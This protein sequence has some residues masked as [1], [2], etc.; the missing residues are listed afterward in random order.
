[1]SS[2]RTVSSNNGSVDKRILLIGG[3]I[4]ILAI[5]FWAGSRVPQ[6]DEKAAMGGETSFNSLGFET[7]LQV[8][9]EHS[10]TRKILYTTVNWAETNKKGM[11]FG[12]LFASCLMTLFTVLS[13][14]SF[15]SG[16]ANSALGVLIGA[17]L[18]VCVNCA[19][20][21]AQGMSARGAR[22]ETTLATM[23][24]SPTMNFI[25]LTMLFSMFPI[26]LVVIK[27]AFT[28]GFIL[29]VIPV[30]ARFVLNREVTM[31]LRGEL[32][33]AL[34]PS[35]PIPGP[36]DDSTRQAMA[37]WPRT[38]SWV[39]KELFRNLGYILRTTV[40]LMLLAGFLGSAM[41]TVIPWG[42][43]A[44]VVPSG[45]RLTT[46]VGMGVVALVGT[47]LPVPIAFDVIICSVLLA[48]GMP[49]K[50]VTILLFTLGIYSV[51]S[52]SIVWQAISTRA[53]VVLFVLLAA[54]GVVAGGLG[55]IF[56]KKSLLRNQQILVE[57]F[58]NNKELEEP[59]FRLERAPSSSRED[60]PLAE[61]LGAQSGIPSRLPV[62]AEEGIV[63]HRFPFQ[64]SKAGD[65]PFSRFGGGVFGLNE[66][67][68]FSFF[69]VNLPF[70]QGHGRTISTGDVHNDSWVDVLFTSEAGLSLYANQQG[71]SFVP[72]VVDIPALDDA[73]VVNAALVDLNN[74]GWLDIFLST[75]TKGNHLIYND[76]EGG[77]SAA[78]YHAVPTADN[79][80]MTTAFAFGDLD[81]DGDLDVVIGKW[82]FALT[83]TTWNT[84][85]RS[86]NAVLFNEGGSF[87]YQ[88]L[89][90]IPGAP[91]TILITD[92]N[93]DGHQ[94]VIVGNDFAAPDIFYLGDG[95]GSFEILTKADGLVPH[96]TTSTMSIAVGD[97][98][99]DLQQEIFFGDI[100][101]YPDDDKEHPHMSY[102][103]VCELVADAAERQTCLV[104]AEMHDLF[105][106]MVLTRDVSACLGIAQEQYQQE[107][108][109]LF[110][111]Q[112]PRMER[113]R[114][115]CA[116]LPESW[117]TMNLMCATHS[118]SPF[119][120][121]EQ[122]LAP[123]IPQTRD[124]NVLLMRGEDGL[125]RDRAAEMGV[126]LAGW[127]WTIKFA[128]LDNDE[129]MDLYGVNGTFLAREVRESNFFFH[130]QQGRTFL[131]RTEEFGLVSYYATTSSSYTD[132]DDD[133]DMDIITIPVNAPVEVFVNNES[134]RNSIAFEL[135]DE[136]GNSFG[137]GSRVTIH[138]GEG[139][140]RH[141]VREL[142]ASGGKASFD[143][144]VAHFGLGAYESVSGVE[145]LWSTGARSE[146]HGE[147]SAGELYRITRESGASTPRS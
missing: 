33:A 72:Q 49:V 32:P 140:S 98:D 80:V 7:V 97:I 109:I 100:A 145:I 131:E 143:A 54:F 76:G 130:N 115:L 40:P 19:A 50:Y 47:F 102:T 83:N 24:S 35:C 90:G 52:F 55:H 25:V 114:E 12:V 59:T 112:K 106:T 75:Y 141:Q 121:T 132:F 87:R 31:S 60:A 147:F 34:T 53:A 67:H 134:E 133:G 136:I 5:S 9:P 39:G 11:I 119:R 20:P 42:S 144:P 27:I 48:S 30:L 101:R 64:P 14:K 65:K 81:R 44:E 82:S 137:I 68:R 57:Y 86:H 70:E 10:V 56:H 6:L 28:L 38:F 91:T 41:I 111:A 142:L 3:I 8:Q 26:H 94:D 45:T 123:L 1:M 46:L 69:K 77:L 124:N 126:N 146:I 4:A 105:S 71:K 79:E 22:L 16:L 62:Q 104:S 129:W 51:Y 108:T 84:S 113:G 29:L 127:V 13:K 116:L 15:K 21:L 95:E 58:V 135:R 36:M 103:E 93:D 96:S 66:P 23:M 107:C 89:P 139:G 92:I 73:V 63:V 61:I 99:N 122:Q 110:F 18:G 125:F 85:V 88:R 128:D 74:D 17:P 2:S 117:Q 138:Y 37:A 43:L 78:G 118:Q 120:P